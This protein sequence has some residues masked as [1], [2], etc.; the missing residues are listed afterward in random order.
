MKEL[1]PLEP[2]THE[3]P[4]VRQRD[5]LLLTAYVLAQQ[6]Y[7]ERA[8]VLLE[9]LH[10]LNSPSSDVFFGR[11]VL[12]FFRR[13]YRAALGCLEELDR[14]DPIERFGRYRLTERQRMRRFLKARCLYELRE[15]AR[16]REAVEVYLRHGESSLDDAG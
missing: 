3:R 8:A 11:A 7:T 15:D 4:T 14:F 2:P 9:A 1:A 12:R 16:A 5:F 6:G 10:L 13:D